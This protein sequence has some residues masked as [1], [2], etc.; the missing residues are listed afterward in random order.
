M[1]RRNIGVSSHDGLTGSYSESE[2]RLWEVETSQS[3][4]LCSRITGDLASEH[5]ACLVDASRG[6]PHANTDLAVRGGPSFAK[7][8]RITKSLGSAQAFRF[9]LICQRAHREF[10]VLEPTSPVCALIRTWASDRRPR[11]TPFLDNFRFADH[12]TRR[13]GSVLI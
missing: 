13:A 7:K 5:C 11:R 1:L 8:L 9:G 4:F 2:G 10:A 12:P 6:R 3:I